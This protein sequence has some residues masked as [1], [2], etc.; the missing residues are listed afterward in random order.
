M[1]NDSAMLPMKRR[2]LLISCS[3]M[4]GIASGCIGDDV[5]EDDDGV[6]LPE[7][8]T[9]EL[10]DESFEPL[11]V[12]IA[13]GGTVTWE[14]VGDRSY[15]IEAYQLHAASTGWSF[16]ETVDPGD[17]VSYTFDSDGRYD[18]V[19][20]AY[21]SFTMCSRV[22]VGNTDEGESLPCS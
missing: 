2:T 11:E 13:E 5:V 16:R 4:A 18:L 9:V 17:S 19:D 20:H 10:A 8:A 22:R 15:R 21:G 7:E 12:H 1:M 3:G 14:N 6:E